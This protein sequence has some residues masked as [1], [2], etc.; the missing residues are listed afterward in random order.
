MVVLVGV[1]GEK[2][3]GHRREEVKVGEVRSGLAVG[4]ENEMCGGG[5]KVHR[6]GPT[7]GER[8]R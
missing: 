8:I 7:L 3:S 5:R 1:V 2:R 4:T 6:P